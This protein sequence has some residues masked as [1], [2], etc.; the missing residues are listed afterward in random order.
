MVA[1][2]PAYLVSYGSTGVL[3]RF[4][5]P[6]PA[7]Y[8]RGDRVV[9][10][11]ERGLTVG[12]VLC[13]AGERHTRILATTSEGMLLRSLTAEDEEAR[14]RGRIVAERIFS[15]SRQLAV[16]LALPLQI[17]DVEVS[18]DGRRAVLQYLAGGPC[19]ATALLD[20]LSERHRLQVWMENLAA[21]AAAAEEHHGCGKPD[22][23]RGQGGCSSCGTGG[24]SSCG[25]GIDMR[26]YFAH[27]RDK[28]ERRT[29]LL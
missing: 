9:V 29:P 14:R 7:A 8:Q 17:L 5:A 23:G 27:L 26:D 21:P 13:A 20:T 2:T 24:C 22:C 25:S 12:T 3:G 19:E 18:L 11:C 28:M 4:L 16:A 1:Q 10:Q 15:D 6:E